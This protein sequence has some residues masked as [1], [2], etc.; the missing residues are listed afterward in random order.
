M[1]I[2]ELIKKAVNDYANKEFIIERELYR[3]KSYTYQQVYE[4]A[5]SICAYFEKNK[6]K[7][8]DKIIIYLP[9][10]IDYVSLLWA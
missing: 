8:G 2:A 6:I 5:I 10:S 1:I 9:N 7:K 3:R 4:K